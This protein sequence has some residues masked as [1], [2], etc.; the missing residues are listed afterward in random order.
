MS[1]QREAFGAPPYQRFLDSRGLPRTFVYLNGLGWNLL[2]ATYRML[3]DYYKSRTAIG[4]SNQVP[5]R[6]SN[7]LPRRSVMV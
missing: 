5:S 3:L 1:V 6:I 2:L 4:S 7:N